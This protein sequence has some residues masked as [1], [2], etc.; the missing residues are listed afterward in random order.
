MKKIQAFTLIELIVSTIII[1]IVMPI[2]AAMLFSIFRQQIQV[3]KMAEVKRQGDIALS[4]ITTLIN[5]NASTLWGASE[6]CNV[7]SPN[8]TAIT[9]FRDAA[10]ANSFGL[11]ILNGVLLVGPTYQASLTNSKVTVTNL[12]VQCRK[13]SQFTKPLVNVSFTVTYNA[14]AST[15]D[16]NPSLNYST[17]ILIRK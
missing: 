12:L 3:G 9:T 11:S 4:R 1:A 17:F 15:I 10:G 2:V 16:V 14:P 5:S 7:A 8:A 13:I 6:I